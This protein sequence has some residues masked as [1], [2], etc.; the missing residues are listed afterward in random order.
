MTTVQETIAEFFNV[1]KLYKIRAC[2]I[3]NEAGITRVT[4]SN[5][6]TDRCEPTLSA[7][8]MATEA[9]ERLIAQKLGA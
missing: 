6:K 3:A 4:L 2:Q 7:W 9:L 1:A 5:W 8:L